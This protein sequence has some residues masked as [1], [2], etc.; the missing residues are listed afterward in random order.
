MASRTETRELQMYI[1]CIDDQGEMYSPYSVALLCGSEKTKQIAEQF[2]QSPSS[3]FE[4][5]FDGTRLSATLTNR[6]ITN[7]ND[8]NVIITELKKHFGEE[9]IRKLLN[10]DFTEPKWDSTVASDSRL[11]GIYPEMRGIGKTILFPGESI[12]VKCEQS[13]KVALTRYD[14]TFTFIRRGEDGSMAISPALGRTPCPYPITDD[15]EAKSIIAILKRQFG[16]EAVQKAMLANT[17]FRA[18]Q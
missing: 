4:C 2:F 8:V 6:E 9:E 15:H 16:D 11:F 17:Y 18:P 12:R 1:P 10:D 3:Q 7:L 14:G 5:T 13:E